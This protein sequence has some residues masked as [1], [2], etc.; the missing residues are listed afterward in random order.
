[1]GVPQT[2]PSCTPAAAWGRKVAPG[3]SVDVVAVQGA[4]SGDTLAPVVG[5][6]YRIHVSIKF[7]I[8]LY[9]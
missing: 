7:Y 6:T 3:N 8:L 9:P 1:M 4:P 2:N 5:D